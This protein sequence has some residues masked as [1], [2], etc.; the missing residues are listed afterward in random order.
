MS[1]RRGGRCCRKQ[2]GARGSPEREREE[3]DARKNQANLPHGGNAGWF[4]F[5][6]VPEACPLFLCKRFDN[7]RVGLHPGRFCLRQ[8]QL[9]YLDW[10]NLVVV[11]ANKTR[12]KPSE[13]TKRRSSFRECFYV[14]QPRKP[15]ACTR[16]RTA[17][18][19]CTELFYPGDPRACT[20]VD[21]LGFRV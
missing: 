11:P 5:P 1:R 13:E 2:P 20:L 12:E 8:C 21:G 7:S 15:S 16:V 14:L 19:A 17:R 3:A 4:T 9:L 10:L 6:L 18:S